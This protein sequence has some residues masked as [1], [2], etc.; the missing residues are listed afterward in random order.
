MTYSN[1]E[2]EAL[3]LD[4]ADRADPLEAGALREV[5]QNY[6]TASKTPKKS[7]FLELSFWQIMLITALVFLVWTPIAFWLAYG[8]PEEKKPPGSFIEQLG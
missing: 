4:L 7:E 5:A 2:M 8:F 1:K 3:C 6:K